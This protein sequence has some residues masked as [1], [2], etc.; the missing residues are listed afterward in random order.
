MSTIRITSVKDPFDSQKLARLAVAL[1]STADAMGL[2]G[3]MVIQRLD[4]PTFRRI[5]DRIAA[6]GIGREVQAALTARGDRDTVQIPDLLDRMALAIEESPA[7]AHEWPSLTDVFEAD[8]L[9]G[10][11]GISAA[12]LRRY[13]S[14]ARST[15]DDVAGRLHFLATVVGDLA[16][17]YNEIGIRHWFERRRVLLDGKAPADLLREGWDPDGPEAKRIRELARSLGASAAT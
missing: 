6:A 4:L 10:L 14:G 15:P 7:P 1:I 12:S 9:A 5:V 11:L 3:D 13:R 2:L 8:R 17:A 16:G